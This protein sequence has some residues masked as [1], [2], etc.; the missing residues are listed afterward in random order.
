MRTLTALLTAFLIVLTPSLYTQNDFKLGFTGAYP[1]YYNYT[2]FAKINWNYYDAFKMNTWSGWWVGDTNTHLMDI[3]KNRQIEGY[4]QP[5]TLRWAA[6]GRMQINEAEEDQNIRFRYTGHRCGTNYKD[7]TQFGYGQWVRYFNKNSLCNE[8]QAPAGL[9]LWGV[10]ENGFQSYSGLPLD[11]KYQVSFPGNDGNGGEINYVNTYYI[12]P[13]MRISTYDALGTPKDV[14]KI[15]VKAYNGDIVGEFT[16][17]T[18]NFRESTG[19]SYNGQYLD[20]Y[21]QLPIFVSGDSLN[22]GRGPNDPLGELQ[23]CQVDYQIYWYGTV[24]VYIDYVK[25]MDE[26][27]NRLLG[28]QAAV[29]RNILSDQIKRLNKSGQ[30]LREIQQSLLKNGY[31]NCNIECLKYVISLLN[32]ETERKRNE[33]ITHMP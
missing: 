13:R 31:D 24:S 30:N 4:F 7:E 18:V 8:E 28:S 14:A 5:D 2:E 10:Y 20:E 15:I 21:Y 3:L 19:A 17:K 16:I 32:E 11:P 12:K 23:N 27:A 29:I 25:V 33:A 22:R 9:V 6:Y 26:A 1:N